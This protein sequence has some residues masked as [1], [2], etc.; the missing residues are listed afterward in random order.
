MNTNPKTRKRTASHSELTKLKELWSG[1]LPESDCDYWREQFAS[2]RTQASMREE[3]REKL[4]INLTNDM[5]LTRFRHWVVDDDFLK[6][7]QRQAAAFRE[8]L[9]QQGLSDEQLRAELLR[10]AIERALARGDFKFG[11]KAV[12]ADVHAERLQ[13]DRERFKEQLRSKMQAGL[14]ELITYV[15]NDPA[16]KAAYDAFYDSVK[17]HEKVVISRA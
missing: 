16:C 6:E 17:V 4:C 13:L 8:E 12:S 9:E 14:D 7:E 15:R 1:S 10:R 11:L 3:I 5:Q 2:G